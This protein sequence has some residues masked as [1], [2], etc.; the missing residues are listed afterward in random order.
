MLGE[1]AGIDFSSPRGRRLPSFLTVSVESKG[2]Y[3]FL[4]AFDLQTAMN[5]IVFPNE[6]VNSVSYN[7]L[8]MPIHITGNFFSNHQR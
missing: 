2:Q 1:S 3:H 8:T 5:F 7:H 6:R 4:S